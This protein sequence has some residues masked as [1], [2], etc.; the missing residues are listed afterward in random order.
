MGDDVAARR[1]SR[2]WPPIARIRGPDF[3]LTGLLA[4]QQRFREQ[5]GEQIELVLLP[6]DDETDYRLTRSEPQ[7]YGPPLETEVEARF[8]RRVEDRP[9][10]PPERI[11]PWANVD[12]M[13]ELAQ[14][15]EAQDMDLERCARTFGT[16]QLDASETGW[17][18]HPMLGFR[19]NTG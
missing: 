15:A 9:C 12:Y 8:N 18:S 5:R 6:T 11:T 4:Q 3:W 14:L 19:R 10:S 16:L 13:T 7:K 1:P 2:H 17:L